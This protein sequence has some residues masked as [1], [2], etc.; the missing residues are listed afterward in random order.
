[1]HVIR[2][3]AIG[4]MAG[5]LAHP[6]GLEVFCMHCA[7]SLGLKGSA[8]Q[9]ALKQAG[10]VCVEKLV[11]REPASPPPYNQAWVDGEP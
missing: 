11:S 5:N 3:H 6:R 7:H 9:Q 4:P 1:M 2:N 10:H 8:A